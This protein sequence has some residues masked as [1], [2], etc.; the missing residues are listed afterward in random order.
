MPT[1]TMLPR[2]RAEPVAEP[3]WD[4]GSKHFMPLDA[5]VTTSVSV[6]KFAT[7]VS[8][9][10]EPRTRRLCIYSCLCQKNAAGCADAGTLR[11]KSRHGH[12]VEARIR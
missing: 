9:G 8:V 7:A 10:A 4:G 1:M 11:G 12:S 2:R 5:Q 3:F 6:L